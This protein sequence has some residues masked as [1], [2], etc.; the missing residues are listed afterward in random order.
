[1]KSVDWNKSCI[2]KSLAQYFIHKYNFTSFRLANI[3]YEKE[4][5][6][7]SLEALQESNI[8]PFTTH[9]NEKEFDYRY[10]H[11]NVIEP[12]RETLS[13]PFPHTHKK[14]LLLVFSLTILFYSFPYNVNEWVRHSKTKNKW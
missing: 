14:K 4:N 7:Y 12:P 2:D 11:E 10:N 6:I 1:M 13:F 5:K 3:F 9:A 8:Q